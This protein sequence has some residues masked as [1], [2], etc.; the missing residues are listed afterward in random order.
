MKFHLQYISYISPVHYTIIGHWGVNVSELMTHFKA[1]VNIFI[2][3]AAAAFVNNA[4]ERFHPAATAP[5]SGSPCIQQR[6][7]M[8]PKTPL[9]LPPRL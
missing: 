2:I 5:R 4:H 3:G 8:T 6:L 7:E 9:L 1:F